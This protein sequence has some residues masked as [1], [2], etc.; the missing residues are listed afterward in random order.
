MKKNFKR[1]MKKEKRILF[2]Y[3]KEQSD[4]RIS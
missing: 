1:W 4:E 3:F 2:L